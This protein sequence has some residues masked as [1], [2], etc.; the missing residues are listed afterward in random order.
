MDPCPEII[1][2]HECIPGILVKNAEN[3]VFQNQGVIDAHYF[4]KSTF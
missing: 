4:F 1:H 2:I 3:G